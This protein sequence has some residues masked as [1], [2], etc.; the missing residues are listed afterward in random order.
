[1]N[2]LAHYWQTGNIIASGT[3]YAFERMPVLRQQVRRATIG[4]GYAQMQC[5]RSD[6]R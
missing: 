2:A 5:L 6:F 3:F 4:G 1:L